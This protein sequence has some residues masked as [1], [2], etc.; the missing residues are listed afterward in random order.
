MT[1]PPAN[2]IVVSQDDFIL[3]EEMGGLKERISEYT[4]A[5]ERH[6]E[7]CGNDDIM[8]ANKLNAMNDKVR[9]RSGEE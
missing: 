4:I 1:S 2:M 8:T 5:S 9:E 3:E 6:E 7:V